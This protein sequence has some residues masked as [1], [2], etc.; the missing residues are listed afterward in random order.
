MQDTWLNM[1]RNYP[2]AEEVAIIQSCCL[3]AKDDTIPFQIWVLFC[4]CSEWI[5]DWCKEI[6][7]FHRDDIMHSD[8][9]LLFDTN[10]CR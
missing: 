8:S 5:E 10:Y 4:Y 9:Q 7:A 6:L 3:N 2:T 1:K